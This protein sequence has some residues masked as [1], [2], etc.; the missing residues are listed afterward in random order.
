MGNTPKLMSVAQPNMPL[1]KGMVRCH[2]CQ[3]AI[4]KAARQCPQCG[5]PAK[6]SKLGKVLA[7]LIGGFIVAAAALSAS[8]HEERKAAAAVEVQS[9]PA[10]EVTA[11]QLHKDYKANEVSADSTYRGKILRVTGAVKSINKGITDRP[12]IILWTTNEYEGVHANFADEGTL[13]TL[14]IGDHITVRCRGDMMI[15][16]SPMLKDCVLQ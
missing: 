4:A 10:I 11:D 3:T 6:K 12:Y 9:A 5:A 14:K 16:G 15:I 7:V 13:G 1:P 8:D 2:T